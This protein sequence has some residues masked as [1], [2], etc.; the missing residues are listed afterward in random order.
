[1]PVRRIVTHVWAAVCTVVSIL[2]L[3]G[4]LAYYGYPGRLWWVELL[5]VALPGIAVVALVCLIVSVPAR[6][7]R[8]ASAMAVVLFLMLLRHAPWDRRPND[9]LPADGDLVMM[10]FNVPRWWGLEMDAKT[11]EMQQFIGEVSPDLLAL[12]EAGIVLPEA[13]DRVAA[14]PYVAVLIDSLGYR[15]D[16]WATARRPFSTPQAVLGHV[17]FTDSEQ[18]ELRHPEDEGDDAVGATVVS[19]VR[20]TWQGR[21][22]VLYNI[23]LRTYGRD[24]PWKEIEPEPFSADFWLRYLRQYRLAYRVRNWEVTRILEMIEAEDVPV[25]IAGDLNSTPNNLVYRRLADGRQDVFRRA[26]RGWGMTYHNRLPVVRIDFI[27]VGPEWDV[28]DAYVPRVWLSDHRPVV[29]R[30]RWNDGSLS[31]TEP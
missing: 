19:R 18:V 4:Y 10:T 28:V 29:A 25:I 16:G 6:R 9:H 12:Q 15:P 22:T 24:K 2:F 26:G 8:E 14:A 5:A 13:G 7:W 30:M 11:S 20:F 3:L 31:D 1:M 27:L 23:H 17:P 21:E